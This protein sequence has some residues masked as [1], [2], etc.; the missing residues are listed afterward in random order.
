MT[1][2]KKILFGIFVI[3][4]ISFVAFRWY[5]FFAG[6]A[7]KQ[8]LEFSHKVHTEA[9]QCEDCHGDIKKPYSAGLPDIKVCMGCH[10]DKP[11]TDSPEEKK[12]INYINQNKDISWKRLYTIPVHV[13]F[14]HNRHVSVAKLEC[15]RCHGD[16]G[17]TVKPPGRP[18]VDIEMS[19][20]ISCH[21]KNNVDTSCVICHR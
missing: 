10:G 8:P 6:A 14:S 3:L 9:A 11:A 18:L 13:Y 17:K 15:E 2:S 20:C 21:K 19:R 7:V 16:I 5:E 4:V 1:K 12:L